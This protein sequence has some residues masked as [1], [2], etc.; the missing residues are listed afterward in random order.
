MV[1]KA[2]LPHSLYALAQI[3]GMLHY[4]EWPEAEHDKALQLY[5]QLLD[6]EKKNKFLLPCVEELARIICK[7]ENTASRARFNAPTDYK[8]LISDKPKS[9]LK[10][11]EELWFI[12]YLQD[13]H[14]DVFKGAERLYR[15]AHDKSLSEYERS[16]KI[17]QL[18]RVFTRA[19]FEFSAHKP[20]V[21]YREIEPIKIMDSIKRSFSCVASTRDSA[22]QAVKK[23]KSAKRIGFGLAP[24]YK[25]NMLPGN[26]K[27][28]EHT[29]APARSNSRSL[30]TAG[31]S[32]SGA[33]ADD[34]EE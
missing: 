25:R 6:W 23:F 20:P 18:A 11:I 15:R 2:N 21:F 32:T 19:E 26:V 12:S 7:L 31:W 3:I 34:R 10:D 22:A 14:R 27:L 33:F 24:H 28:D 30:Y 1:S 5:A 13:A 9:S 16:R 29:T 4:H 17:E 8:Q